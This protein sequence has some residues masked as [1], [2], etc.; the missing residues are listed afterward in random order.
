MRLDGDTERAARHQRIRERLEALSKW[1]RGETPP[2]D[3]AMFV[4]T[5]EL[6]MKCR[7]VVELIEKLIET[8]LEQSNR[9]S[10]TSQLC[11]LTIRLDDLKFFCRTASGPLKRLRHAFYADDEDEVEG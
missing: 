6:D 11:D 9:D 3:I 10:L 2:R 5:A 7:D 1:A 4:D 8:P